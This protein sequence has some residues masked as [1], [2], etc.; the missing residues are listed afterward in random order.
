M[1]VGKLACPLVFCKS[2]MGDNNSLQ[3]SDL[4]YPGKEPRYPQKS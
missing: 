1:H 4:F 3:V 2:A